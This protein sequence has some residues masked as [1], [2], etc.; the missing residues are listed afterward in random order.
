M[1]VELGS[2]DQL[3]REEKVPPWLDARTIEIE[4]LG[5]QKFE[6]SSE[7]GCLTL[8]S[9]AGRSLKIYP[10]ASNVIWVGLRGE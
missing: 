1:K 8:R 9:G 2:T 7:R 10:N 6:V 5:G 4:L 3:R